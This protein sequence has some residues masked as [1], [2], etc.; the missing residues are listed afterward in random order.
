M[1]CFGKLLPTLLLMTGRCRQQ[2]TTR[3][4]PD[5]TWP[6]CPSARPHTV[7]AFPLFSQF[8]HNAGD[9]QRH[10]LYPGYPAM[11]LEDSRMRQRQRQRQRISTSPLRTGTGMLKQSLILSTS[12]RVVNDAV[13]DN[14][15]CA[16]SN[17]TP[18]AIVYACRRRTALEKFAAVVEQRSEDVV[19]GVDVVAISNRCQLPW[20]SG[21]GH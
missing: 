8:L 14:S 15:C 19:L 21:F 3:D 20:I 11:D 17:L 12:G 10:L 4:V 6:A 18:V 7:I 1:V 2:C 9:Q 5:H 13:R 16:W